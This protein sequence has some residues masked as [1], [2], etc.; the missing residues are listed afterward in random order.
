MTD[1]R[2]LGGREQGEVLACGKG[3]QVIE[4]RGALGL[5]EFY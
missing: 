2:L 3:T 5:I 1:L 4:G